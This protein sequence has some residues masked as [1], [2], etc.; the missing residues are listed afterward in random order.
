MFLFRYLDPATGAVQIGIETDSG[1]RFNATT[2][3]PEAFASVGAWLAQD[4]P[5]G[6]ARTVALTG[7]DPVPEGVTLRAPVDESEVWASGVTYER[8]RTAR[9]EESQ[10]AGGGDFYD[11]VY[12]AHRPELFFKSVGWRVVAPGAKVRIRRDSSW[13]V[14]E[15]EMVLV[16]SAGGEI[17]GVTAGNDMSSRSIE[18]ENPLYLPQAKTYDG[19]CAVGAVI[20]I[21]PDIAG[22]QNRAITLHI[23]RRSE[24]VFTGATNTVTMK[25]TPTELVGYLL[26]ETAF[27]QGAFLFTGTGIVPP[28]DFTLASGDRITI[29]V[30]GVAPLIN[31]VA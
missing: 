27:P 28:D 8:S 20:E 18:G 19:A 10:G 30:A 9:R 29:T 3:A 13:N 15:P 2:V 1:E 26:R 6:V 7:G 23:E 25:R 17:V 24:T 4:D 31:T 16:V 22:L 12:D 5:V 14:P 11:R 21:A